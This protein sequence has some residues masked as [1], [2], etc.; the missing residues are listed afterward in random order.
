MSWR[1]FQIKYRPGKPRIVISDTLV[2]IWTC[3]ILIKNS[4]A[5]SGKD[6]LTNKVDS[7]HVLRAD[8]FSWNWVRNSWNQIPASRAKFA[9]INFVFVWPCITDTII[10]SVPL[11]NE[12]GISLIILTPMKIL[13][14][15]LNSTCYDV[16]TFLTQRGKSASNF[17]AISSLVVKLLKKCR[18]R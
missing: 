17:V 16:V 2:S 5:T 4:A 1:D 14:R 7:I 8:L 11:A 13:Q 10:Q 9:S 15:N 6:V 18:V 3:D 12:P